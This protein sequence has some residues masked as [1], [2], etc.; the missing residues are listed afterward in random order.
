MTDSSAPSSAA[1]PA[2]HEDQKLDDV[3]LAMDVVDT[4][5]HREKMVARELD[6]EEREAELL[7]RLKEIYVAQGIEVPER[8][9]KDGVA[10]LKEQRFAYTPPRNSLPVRLARIY[11]ARDRWI[12]PVVVSVTAL[13]AALGAYEFGVARPERLR[14]EDVRIEVTETLPNQLNALRAEIQDIAAEA[15][16]DALAETLYQDGLAALEDNKPDDARD[17]IRELET[18]KA[19][20]ARTYEVRVRYANGARSGVFRI[21]ENRPGQRNYYLIVEAVDPRGN[22]I[23][24]PIF[25]E[26]RQTQRR[27]TRWG[28]RVSQAVFNRVAEDKQDDQIIQNDVIGAKP[29]GRLK[30]AYTVETPGG[31]ILE[32]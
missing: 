7:S 1:T 18:L 26:E 14:A 24:V 27:A 8:I 17:L 12:K 4:L 25:D 32:W 20:I 16:V 5:R 31:A 13:V 29:S 9:L 2:D 19:D 22:L 6:E 21:P 23:E 28:Q 10:A 15:D 11:I 3:L 30:P